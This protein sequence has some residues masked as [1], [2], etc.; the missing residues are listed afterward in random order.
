MAS[1]IQGKS[2]FIFVFLLCLKTMFY[3]FRLPESY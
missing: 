3:R 1:I 2:L